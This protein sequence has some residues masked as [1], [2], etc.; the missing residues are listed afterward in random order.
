MSEDDLNRYNDLVA[1]A[2]PFKMVDHQSIAGHLEREVIE[3]RAA[4]KILLAALKVIAGGEEV[5]AAAV[6]KNALRTLDS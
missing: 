6:A 1:R 5:E 2:D 4:L 3:L